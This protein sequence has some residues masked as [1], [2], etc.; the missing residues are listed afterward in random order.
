M[1]LKLGVAC[2]HVG[3]GVIQALLGACFVAVAGA[4]ALTSSALPIA[5]TTRLPT[6]TTAAG[7]VC[8]GLVHL[9]PLDP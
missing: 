7:F 8:A 9:D 1:A 3:K 2:L 5:A 6:A 4:T